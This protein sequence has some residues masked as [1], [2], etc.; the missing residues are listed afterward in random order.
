MPETQHEDDLQNLKDALKRLIDDT[1]SHDDGQLLQQSSLISNQIVNVSGERSVGLGNNAHSNII[2]IGDTTF[3]LTPESLKFLQQLFYQPPEL[4]RRDKLPPGGDLPLGSHIPFPPNR[5]FTGREDDLLKTANS[6]LFSDSKGVSITQAAAVAT[7]MGGIGKTQMAIEFCYIYGQFFHGVH[8]IQADY[9]HDIDAEIATCG[10]EMGLSPWPDK[11]DERVKLTI[12]AWKELGPRL[13]VF[14][15]VEDYD[16]VQE[17]LPR[18]SKARL[19]LTSRSSNLPPDLDIEN[20]PL[21]VLTR[22]ESLKLLRKLAKRLENVPDED[23]EKVADRLGDLPL[24]LDLAGNYL[25]TRPTLSSVGYLKEMDEAGRSILEHR[26]FNNWVKHNPNRHSTSLVETFAASWEQLTE[27]ATDELARRI[28]RACGYCTTNTPIPWELMKR[29]IGAEDT[30]Q[31]QNLD[32]AMNRL[33]GLG[34]IKKAEDGSSSIIHPLMAEFA[35]IKDMEME[36]RAL[37][38]LADALAELAYEANMSGL[39]GNV[40][41]LREHL[42]AVA[43]AIEDSDA[44]LEMAASLWTNLG[45]HLE[46]VADYNDAKMIDERA[47]EIGEKAY[48]PNHPNVAIQVNNLGNVLQDMGKLEEAKKLYERA[49]EIDEKTYGP[50]HTSVATDVNNLGNVLQDMGKLE[51]AKRLYERAL[52]INEKVLGKDHPNTIIVRKN[53]GAI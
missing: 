34:L 8:W 9:N 12:Q 50:N 39:P 7:G 29:T 13:V 28:F 52:E 46:A 44:N 35:R 6:L 17:W 18:L 24:A 43:K 16:L 45:Y 5:V 38:D 3:T 25:N 19:L 40:E 48:G 31:Q 47:L 33:Y 42:R 2:I 11:L 41:P 27:G 49:L 37:P 15:N 32:R 30:S 22:T 20:I 4:P 51:E 53:L 26:A 21:D 36:D 10:S 1:P 23:L 14:D